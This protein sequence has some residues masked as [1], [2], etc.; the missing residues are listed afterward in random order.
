MQLFN[1]TALGNQATRDIYENRLFHGEYAI[2]MAIDF[3]KQFCPEDVKVFYYHDRNDYR[4]F[5]EVLPC[6]YEHTQIRHGDSIPEDA[7]IVIINVYDIHVMQDKLSRKTVYGFCTDVLD[8][9]PESVLPL[10]VT[11]TGKPQWRNDAQWSVMLKLNVIPAN[12][13]YW[14]NPSTTQLIQAVESN[15][16]TVADQKIYDDNS[17]RQLI[18]TYDCL[19]YELTEDAVSGTFVVRDADANAILFACENTNPDQL[20]LTLPHPY[21]QCIDVSEA[22]DIYAWFVKKV[23]NLRTTDN[24]CLHSVQDFCIKFTENKYDIQYSPV[25]GNWGFTVFHNDTLYSVMYSTLNNNV[26]VITGI[27][28]TVTVIDTIEEAWAE[29]FIDAVRDVLLTQMVERDE[30]AKQF[31]S[32]LGRSMNYACGKSFSNEYRNGVTLPEQFGEPGELFGEIQISVDKDG[33]DALLE[34][35]NFPACAT[36]PYTWLFRNYIHD[37]LISYDIRMEMR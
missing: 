27:S 32:V 25:L 31:K 28:R 20:H 17:F 13:I 12:C 8:D 4:L 6:S 22:R 23:R 29:K 10:F 35:R 37:I 7:H 3:A 19:R 5:E 2:T 14:Y 11:S 26:I 15:M 36:V 33:N 30:L 21:T 9:V 34:C 24:V 18:C 1:F 16:L